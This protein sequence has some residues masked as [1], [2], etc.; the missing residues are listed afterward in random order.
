MTWVGR[1]QDCK[2][3]LTP[4]LRS[5]L[6]SRAWLVVAKPFHRCTQETDPE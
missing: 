4:E 2:M 1:C 3:E 6:V 5:R